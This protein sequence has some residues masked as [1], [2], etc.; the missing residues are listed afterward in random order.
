M[1]SVSPAL[2]GPVS[3]PWFGARL[4]TGKSYDVLTPICAKMR[5]ISD[6]LQV[7]PI[8]LTNSKMHFTVYNTKSDALYVIMK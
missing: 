2:G 4:L 3:M 7:K 6:W 5:T 8:K 1:H